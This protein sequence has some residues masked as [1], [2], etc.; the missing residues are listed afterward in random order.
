MADGI[1]MLDWSQCMNDGEK[2]R[3]TVNG[4][5]VSSIHMDAVVRIFKTQADDCNC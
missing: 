5:H 4:S 2:Y 3:V 1:V